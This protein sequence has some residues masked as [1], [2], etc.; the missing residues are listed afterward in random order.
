MSAKVISL[1]LI[2]MMIIGFLPISIIQRSTS[3]SATPINVQASLMRTPEEVYSWQPSIIFA[4]VVG[5][6]VRVEL[7]V[8][9]RI[10]V[11]INPPGAI[12]IPSPPSITYT[13]VMLPISYAPGWYAAFIPG[14]PA[15]TNQF[16]YK[17]P[18]LP[19]VEVIVKVKSEVNYKLVIDGNVVGSGGYVV[20]EGEVERQLPPQVLAIVYDALEDPTILNETLGL[21]PKGWTINAGQFMKVLI[22]AFDDKGFKD[23]NGL[24]FEYTVD[25]GSWVQ[26][27]VYEDPLMQNIKRLVGDVNN[28]LQ[29]IEKALQAINP[30]FDI[31]EVLPSILVAYA[32]VPGHASGSYV[33]FRANAMDVDGNSFTSPM[34][35]YYV[36]NKESKVKVLIVDSHVWLWLF[37][38]N[39]KQLVNV[40]E[41]NFDYK[42]PSDIAGNI[43][44]VNRIAEILKKYW[45]VPFHHWELLGKHYNLYITWPD[46]RIADLLKGQD[47][48]GF[49]PHAIVLSSLALAF[50]ATERPSPWNWDLKDAGVLDDVVKYVKE[51]HAGL[52]ATHG[53]LSDWVV[54]TSPESQGHYKV[55]SRGHVGKAVG[56]VNIVNEST[57]AALLGMPELALWE[58]VRD[59]VANILCASGETMSIGL[60]VGSIPLQVPHIPFNGSMK[61]TPEAK[62]IGWNI[63][64]EFNILIPSAYNEF[65]VSAYTQIG[66]Q[67]A[68]PRALA[69]AAWWEAQEMRPL[70]ERLY[71]KLSGLIEN[72]T[73]GIY[74]SENVMRHMD[75]SLRWALQSF[76]RS[77]ISANISDTTFSVL[78]NVPDLKENL[79]LTLD[80]SEVHSQLLQLLPVKLVALSKDGLAGII[81]HDKYWTQK[82]YRAVYFSFEVEAA[83]GEIAETLLVNAIEWSIKWQYK[84]VM[85]LLGGLVLVPKELAT[86][87]NDTLAGLPGNLT[88][89]KGLIL[90]EEGY[91]KMELLTDTSQLLHILIA[92]PTSD[93]VEAEV[94][95][96]RAEIINITK[97]T[98]QLT[99][100]TARA[101]EA[102]KVT[103]GL[104][105]GSQLALNPAYVAVKQGVVAQPPAAAKFEISNLVISPTDVKVGE[106]LTISVSVKNVGEVE[107]MYTVVLKINNVVEAS[108]NISLAAGESTVVA[109]MV[110]MGAVGMYEV[111][112]DG[113]KGSII[114]K[115]PLKPAEFRVTELFISPVEVQPREPVTIIVKV[116]NTG[117]EGGSY[118]VKLKVAGVTVDSKTVTLAGGESTSLTFTVIKDAAGVYDVEVDGQRGTI[119][120]REA[121]PTPPSPI[122][123]RL[124]YIGAA[125]ALVAI[126]AIAA[127]HIK[128][129][130]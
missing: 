26:A 84:D 8:T 79:T 33:L 116:T 44:S 120:V 43:A 67:L 126:I 41:Q 128:R 51:K 35:F 57:I 85:D 38:E 81:T 19:P 115:A 96:G 63:P 30:D 64:E 121:T 31:P 101:A 108:K 21:G 7:E 124:P 127:F 78:I 66:W 42:L 55:G 77:I 1:L 99:R 46:E 71:D 60:L 11:T 34:G 75:A 91:T 117:E 93:E 6:Y 114:V 20:L 76:Y 62:Y 10:S 92:H 54:W 52:I 56:D 68:M 87:F 13:M 17:R 5:N 122:E 32:E 105:A 83:E 86:R 129:K 39:S 130:K 125:I 50:N 109:F 90:N 53:T 72:I 45:V 107:G 106:N 119:V 103:L 82:G 23:I 95:K 29:Q 24:S 58:Y 111:E 22:L 3:L 89:L 49:E 37:Q 113:L 100:I 14:L 70:A 48:G 36:V 102:E 16:K 112:I 27:P 25:G 15:E 69:Y 59:Q 9:V 110:R 28:H 18:L 88:I 65:N 40:L 73:Q 98:G 12:F 94:L 61:T 80:V 47:D 74:S 4:H 104:R 97:V 2:T 123:H 118:N